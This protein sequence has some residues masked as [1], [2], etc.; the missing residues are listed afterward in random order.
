MAASEPALVVE[1]TSSNTRAFDQAEK[2][3]EYNTVETL[4]GD[5]TVTWGDHG[6]PC[7]V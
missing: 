4:E 5:V 1:I 7:L 3:D 6:K 2:I